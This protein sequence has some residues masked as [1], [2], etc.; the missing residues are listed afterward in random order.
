MK[1]VTCIDLFCGAGGLTHGL[2]KEGINVVAGVDIEESCRHPFQFNNDAIFIKEDI[3]KVSGA[4]LDELFGNGGV[5]VLA[6]CAPCQPFSTY[7]QRY[8]V[9]SSPRWGLLYQFDRLVKETRPDIVTM[10]NVPTVAKHAVFDDFSASLESQGY[11]V[12]REVID[13]IKYGLPQTRRRMVLLAS[14]LGPIRTAAPDLEHARSVRD[15]IGDLP[16]ISHGESYAADPLHT[17]SRLSPLNVERIRAS[18]PGGSWRDWPEHLVAACHKKDS[19]KT[20][21]GVYGRMEWDNPAPTLTTQ[22]YGFGN[23]R[24]GHPDQDRA[25]SLREGAILQ[26]FPTTYSFV[27]EGEPIHFKS[28]GRMIGNAVPVTLGEVIGRSIIAHLQQFSDADLNSESLSIN[29][30]CKPLV[31]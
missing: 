28:L 4:R 11:F 12:H 10:E 15:A 29:G 2:Q 27:P 17:A 7:S 14:K 30:E 21:P 5:K 8:D 26:G 20:Y 18:K 23:G 16:P 31:A 3:S 13:C 19:G 6:G 25:I 9:L 24:F 1:D 22:Y